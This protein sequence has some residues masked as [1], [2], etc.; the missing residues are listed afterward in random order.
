MPDFSFL[1]DLIQS[2]P[3]AAV[4]L[5]TGL[6]F[7]ATALGAAVVFVPMSQQKARTFQ[8]LAMGFAAGIMIAAS[9][10]SLLIP[11]ME[12]AQENGVS[13]WLPTTGGFLLGVAFVALLDKITPHMH[14]ALSLTARR[15]W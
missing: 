10:W 13:G 15:C 8:P 2:G 9:V 3:L 14:P 7:A 5:G 1:S 12:H 6:S 11:A 4:L